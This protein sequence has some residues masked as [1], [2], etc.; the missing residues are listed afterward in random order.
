MK[1]VHLICNAHL[2]PIWLWPWHAGLTE[3]LATARSVCNLLDDY[4]DLTFTR[5][6]SWFYQQIQRHDPEL[7]GRIRTFVEA[8]RWEIVGGWY[9]QPDCNQPGMATFE[10]LVDI[11][12]R[13]F[14]ENFSRFPEIAYNVDS[15]G[16]HASLPAFM[17]RHGQK[18]Y[19][20]MR[21]QEHEMTLPAR[22]FQ[23][24]GSSDDLPVTTFRIAG[25][26]C[27]PHGINERHI[28]NS[29]SELPPGIDHTMC[30]VGLGDHGG[31]PSHDMVRWCTE[32]ADSFPGAK[33]IFST[34][35]RF[36]SAIAGQIESLPQVTG[37]L[38][39]HAIG[40]YSV[41]HQVKTLQRQ[42]EQNLVRAEA[43]VP[44]QRQ[45]L[46]DAWQH[47]CFHSFHDTLGGTC[48][49]SAYPAVYADLSSAISVAD[50]LLRHK[51]TDMALALPNDERQ[52]MIFWNPGPNRFRGYVECEPWLEWNFWKPAWQIEDDR[53]QVVPYQLMASEGHVNAMTRLLFHC[54]IAPNQIA[55][56]R[57]DHTQVGQKSA[58]TV[59]D[60]VKSN[61]EL[62]LINNISTYLCVKENGGIQ[63]AGRTFVLPHLVLLDDP[64]DTWSHGVDRYSAVIAARVH[65]QG[66]QM[67][68]S[69]PLMGSI[70][71]TG[72]I[73]Q[74]DFE[75]E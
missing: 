18:Y 35:S 8:G 31:G 53:G 41:G 37:E 24:R 7:F 46:N 21:P 36:F 63:I 54:D 59:I 29:L 64:T 66:T 11:G 48:I 6:E 33:L 34:P 43:A 58:Q 26:Y 17:R 57:F 50:D 56:F 49:P 69:G 13:Y 61:S 14:V 74:S 72:T 55:V 42:A 10:K 40:C 62:S 68:D 71:Q 15:F 44:D 30:F 39:M 75:A 22:I 2:D 25:A 19:I 28:L 70:V 73:G 4:P 16:H 3:A 60:G 12:R 32:H 65:V 47:V 38:Q 1:I 23:W 5:G 51:M 9:V 27:T 67:V 52:R 20:M 45:R